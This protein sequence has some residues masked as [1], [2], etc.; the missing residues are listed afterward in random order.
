MWLTAKLLLF[1][2]NFFHRTGITYDNNQSTVVLGTQSTV[3]LDMQST[4]VLGMES[5]VASGMQA[6]IISPTHSVPSAATSGIRQETL[7]PDQSSLHP[8]HQQT[9]APVLTTHNHGPPLF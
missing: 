5:T 7:N 9:K 4:I 8:Q 1:G 6:G 2:M 3:V